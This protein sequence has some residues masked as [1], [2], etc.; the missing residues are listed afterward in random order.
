ML[1]YKQQKINTNYVS[2]THLTSINE[3]SMCNHSS[4]DCNCQMPLVYR[5]VWWSGSY[6]I[7]PNFRICEK[8]I[9]SLHMQHSLQC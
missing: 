4:Y 8:N 2:I 5:W 3:A 6:S 7:Y 1:L 9:N